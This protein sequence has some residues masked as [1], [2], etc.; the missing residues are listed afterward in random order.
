LPEKTATR[1][2]KTQGAGVA[3][4]VVKAGPVPQTEEKMAG[5]KSKVSSVIAVLLDNEGR[6]P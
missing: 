4:L 2:Q 1:L 3:W 5:I 6:Q